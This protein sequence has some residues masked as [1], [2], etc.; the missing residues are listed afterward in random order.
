MT[1]AVLWKREQI[2][3]AELA[4]LRWG[5]KWSTRRLAEHFGV[6]TTTLKASLKH[7]NE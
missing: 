7:I 6:G 1:I 5:K 3:L 2:N 4:A